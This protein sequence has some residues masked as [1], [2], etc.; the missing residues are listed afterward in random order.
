MELSVGQTIGDYEI[1]GI[2]GK[3][4]MGK[5]YKVRNCITGRVEAMKILLPELASKPEVVERFSREIQISA[6]LDHPNIAGVHTAHR[7]G[8]QLIMVMEL[9]DGE[10]LAGVMNKGRVPLNLTI[11]YMCQALVALNYA[12]SRGVIHRDIKPC[13][14]MLTNGLLKLMDFGI[15]KA[16]GG[17]NLTTAGLLVGSPN[18]MSP[19]QVECKGVDARTDLY[20]L[21]VTLYE[22]VTGQL[23]FGGGSD[24]EVME[25]HV[26]GQAQW[27]KDLVPWLPSGLSEVIMLALSKDRT[28]R[29]QTADAFR[30]ALLV[31]L[32]PQAPK[33]N[34]IIEPPTQT[35][36]VSAGSGSRIW[37]MLAGSGATISAIVAAMTWIPSIIHTGAANES[38]SVARPGDPLVAVDESQSG[39]PAQSKTPSGVERGLGARGDNR[40]P[41]LD[42]RASS[43]LAVTKQ[44]SKR[45]FPQSPILESPTSIPA[46]DPNE[47]ADLKERAN[48]LALR[49]EGV[50]VALE[51][52][53]RRLGADLG[54]RRDL[55]NDDGLLGYLLGRAK[56]SL[57]L[58]DLAETKTRL[59]AAEQELTK[60]E[61]VLGK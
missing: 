59:D 34:M 8:N 61:L 49:A 10:S 25:A 7:I 11:D 9:I 55:V 1:R 47:L 44:N 58:G 51:N 36:G 14:M 20:S 16:I 39:L 18:Y 4:G 46:G 33:Q 32:D 45:V 17:Q 23:P 35:G 50:R 15:A 31:F 26:K 5:V 28:A 57:N 29:F 43:S 3:G 24:Y 12:H 40:R 53:R 27:P 13:N 60:I 48:L 6:S 2:L 21:G 38:V 19:E 52:M 30:S 41:A 54:L 22:I 56:S 42:L 37:Y